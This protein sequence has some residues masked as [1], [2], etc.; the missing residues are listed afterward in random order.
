MSVQTAFV[1]EVLEG[2]NAG[3]VLELDGRAMPYR[4]GSGGSISFGSELQVETT[5]YPGNREA[6]QK[7]IGPRILPTTINGVWKEHYLGENVPQD[8]ANLFTEL[9]DQGCQLRVFWSGIVRRGV[10]RRFLLT[11]GVPTGGMGDIGWEAEF[12]WNAGQNEQ[13]TPKWSQKAGGTS[14]EFSDQCASAVLSMTN[15]ISRL[16]TFAARSDTFVGLVRSSFEPDRREI[17]SVAD[18]LTDPVRIQGQI[19]SR[20]GV[21]DQIPGRLIEQGIGSASGA[22]PIV[23]DGV[24]V[25][26]NVFHSNVSIDDSLDSVLLEALVRSELVDRCYEEV[27]AQAQLLYRLEEIGRPEEFATIEARPGLDLRD[28]STRF[29]GSPDFW[30]RIGRRNG[31]AT[32]V[33]PEGVDRI[34]VPL[35]LPAALDDRLG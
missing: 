11:P 8:L 12:E 27:D 26:A 10:L 23:G 7:I 34:V 20:L 6:E 31:I 22:P 25:V 13:V 5:W 24:A 16:R 9:V 2:P 14:F 28:V 35:Q 1:I 15:L 33:V 19:A 32:S 18:R 17:E 3:A 30:P 21:G 29:Y 4:G